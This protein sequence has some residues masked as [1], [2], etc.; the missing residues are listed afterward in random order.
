MIQRAVTPIRSQ[1]V[2]YCP[3][4]REPFHWATLI[5][6]LVH[7]HEVLLPQRLAL[8]FYKSS[9]LIYKPSL[10]VHNRRKAISLFP[11]WL[12]GNT[13]FFKKILLEF[14]FKEHEARLL[15][16]LLK[17][18]FLRLFCLQS[19]PPCAAR[20]KTSPAGTSITSYRYTCTH[21]DTHTLSWYR[22]LLPASLI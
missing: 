12:L 18:K 5:Q 9:N 2:S 21:T 10:T 13:F 17:R 7:L 1:L 14:K 8:T 3:E 16:Q 19:T 6:T 22:F 20:W 4:Q 15:Y 11:H